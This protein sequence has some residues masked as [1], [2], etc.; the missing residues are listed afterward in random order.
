[1]WIILFSLP[2]RVDPAT[3]YALL[4]G[5]TFGSDRSKAKEYLDAAVFVPGGGGMWNS[6]C[7][8]YIS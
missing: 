6:E 8:C 5:V 3:K 1:M 4:D 2:S 7:A